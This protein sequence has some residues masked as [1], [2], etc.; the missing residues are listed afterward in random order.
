MDNPTGLIMFNETASSFDDDRIITRKPPT[1]ET[2]PPQ[3]D[4]RYETIRQA[5]EGV[6]TIEEEVFSIDE[7]NAPQTLQLIA[8]SPNTRWL[9]SFRGK[10]T[11]PSESAYAQLDGVFVSYNLLPLFREEKR[12]PKSDE[13]IQVVHVL[14]GRVVPPQGGNVIR[15]ILFILTV[16]SMLYVGTISA[17]NEIASEDLRLA[18]QIDNNLLLNL[19]RGIPY[20]GAL[21]LI[22][23]AHELGHYFAARFHKTAASLPYFLPFPFGVFGTLGAAIRLREPMRNR[24]ALLDIGAAGPLVG[25]LFA[26]PIVL[27]GLATSKVDVVS[28]GY[29]EGNSFIY[30]LAKIIVFGRFLPDGQ[31][32]V[33]VNQLAWAGWAG[34]FVTGLNLIPVGQL[35][36]G[37]VLYS[38]LGRQSAVFY[39][40][41]IGGLLLLS[42]TVAPILLIFVLLVLLIGNLHAVPLDDITPLDNRRRWIAVMTLMI[43]ILVFVPTPL[44][45]VI[46]PN[47]D[48]IPLDSRDLMM[49]PALMS[50]LWLR[51][52]DLTRFIQLV[53]SK[54]RNGVMI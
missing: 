42:M 20:A 39:Y 16:I 14:E 51:R 32:D 44:T 29:I 22:L 13:L 26:I 36:G 1:E 18:L 47:A 12:H 40:P 11:A 8:V 53:R 17:I 34:L 21:L 23:G 28:S 19:W 33:Y 50:V 45:L 35:D 7:K 31:V 2:E 24:K 52:H 49:L 15:L 6:M 54:C 27:I 3:Q 4:P 41:I 25:L 38:L 5:V 30:A 43:F 46:V 10:L 9:M 48:G 37:H